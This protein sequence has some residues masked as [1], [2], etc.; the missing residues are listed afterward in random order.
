[1]TSNDRAMINN[2]VQQ[3]SPSNKQVPIGGPKVHFGG[4]YA[5]A[6]ALGEPRSIDSE[7]GTNEDEPTDFHF[8]RQNTPHPKSFQP[9]AS[10]PHGAMTKQLHKSSMID[11]H[12]IPKLEE[13]LF[14]LPTTGFS[15]PFSFCNVTGRVRTIMGNNIHRLLGSCL[16]L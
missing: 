10:N 14:F 12:L 8:Q 1:M 6:V 16:N 9:H 11:G 15:I 5:E 4:G 13:V 2:N 7:S 3:S